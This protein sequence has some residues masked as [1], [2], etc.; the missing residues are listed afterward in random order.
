[1]F[2]NF[3]AMNHKTLYF[4]FVYLFKDFR[5]K[6]SISKNYILTVVSFLQYFGDNHIVKI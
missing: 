5:I 2:V 6:F 1:M 4:S 3:K